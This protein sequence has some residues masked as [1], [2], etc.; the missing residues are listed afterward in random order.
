MQ[1]SMKNCDFR[2]ISRFISEM[3]QD[4]AV[5][6]VEVVCDLSYGAIASKLE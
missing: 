5:V 2:G 6:T 3:T 1:A 4:R